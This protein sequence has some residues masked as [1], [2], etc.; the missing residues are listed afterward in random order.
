MPDCQISS[1]VIYEIS[2]QQLVSCETVV[3]ESLRDGGL[4]EVGVHHVQSDCKTVKD[5]WGIAQGS[6]Q[7]GDYNSCRNVNK[8]T[9]RGGALPSIPLDS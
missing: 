7:G 6:S 8:V 4:D 5:H 1:E 9:V 3:A 2:W